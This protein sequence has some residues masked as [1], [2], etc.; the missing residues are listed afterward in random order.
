M[1]GVR[2]G[3]QT[4]ADTARGALTDNNV[5][6]RS[7]VARIRELGVADGDVRTAHVGI[8]P[9]HDHLGR[10]ARGYRA[11][12]FLTVTIRDAG[13]TG[14]MLDKIVDA[15]ANEVSGVFAGIEDT[16]PLEE[17]AFSR[18]VANA[19]ERAELAARAAGAMVGQVLSISEEV[20]AAPYPEDRAA[21]AAAAHEGVPF[22]PE[23]EKVRAR[24]QVTF[25]LKTNGGS[26]T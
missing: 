5:R 4:E 12:N 17:A 24:V 23:E 9:Q 14:E 22:H 10:V 16:T 18:A 15:G 1:V 2:L 21:F 7:L 3:I 11:S 6:M 20:G 26:T 19:R 13:R 25:E 8:W